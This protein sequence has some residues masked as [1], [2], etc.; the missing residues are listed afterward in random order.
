MLLVYLKHS[1]ELR[2]A[3]PDLVRVAVFMN[4]Q[5]NRIANFQMAVIKGAPRYCSVDRDNIMMIL[6]T[7]VVD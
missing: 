5:R 7:F 3:H 2:L 1:K 6:V 4:L